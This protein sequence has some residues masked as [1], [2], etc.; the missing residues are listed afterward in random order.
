MFDRSHS[1]DEQLAERCRAG[2]QRA[3][4]A[5][6]SRH[7]LAARELALA[8]IGE[9]ASAEEIVAEAFG[10]AAGAVLQGDDQPF[11]ILM[12]EA[13]AS[14]ADSH[15]HASDARRAAHSVAPA[16]TV[17]ASC[18]RGSASEDAPVCDGPRS[19]LDDALSSAGSLPED[20]LGRAYLG[21]DAT[22]RVVLWHA[23][24]EDSDAAEL[25]ASL[26]VRSARV[27]RVVHGSRARLREAY[28]RERLD[29]EPDARCRRCV[30]LLGGYVDG[31][32]DRHDEQQVMSHLD[33]CD[34]CYELHA[35]LHEL[36]GRLRPI[37][38]TMIVGTAAAL[39][40]RA[41]GGGGS[42][43]V[44]AASS[45][46]NRSS[47]D[48]TGFAA[49]ALAAV[50]AVCLAFAA[51]GSANARAVPAEAKVELA[52]DAGVRSYP[53]V[54]AAGSGGAEDARAADGPASG[55][56]SQ[57]PGPGAARRDA[58]SVTEARGADEP[59]D[60]DPSPSAPGSASTMSGPAEGGG[61]LDAGRRA[62]AALE[63]PERA[64]A[65]ESTGVPIRPVGASAPAPASSVHAPP[66]SQPP[67]P[68]PLPSVDKPPAPAVD[69]SPPVPAVDSPLPVDP[70]PL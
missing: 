60:G 17:V 48:R 59:S 64:T 66:A 9:D 29:S 11:R 38:A 56:P 41:Q 21:L 42:S 30:E 44:V 27:S 49:N 45:R 55:T 65:A 68:D 13:V 51:V 32:L 69:P 22:D 63:A 4:A 20:P 36:G 15:H 67:A 57:A 28:L 39:W 52:S 5:L 1:S 31:G 40:L 16:P 54:G 26:G 6:R 35:E 43:A 33:G 62:D 7:E 50:A 24:V 10:R 12:M 2:E 18:P 8:L 47:G 34:S 53:A 58:S 61:A 70:S 23:D 3:F 25:A 37:A 14:V 46:G 19:R